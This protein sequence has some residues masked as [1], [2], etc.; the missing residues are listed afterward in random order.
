MADIAEQEPQQDR[1]SQDLARQIRDH[2]NITLSTSHVSGVNDSATARKNIVDTAEGRRA[3][4]SNYGNAPGGAV[5]LDVDMLTGMLGL[6]G[7]YRFRV[8][9][10]AGGSHSANSRHYAGVAFDVDQI[11]GRQVNSNNPDYQTFMQIGR[12]LGA[13]E[14]LGPGNVGHDTHV[15]LAWPRRDLSEKDDSKPTCEGGQPIT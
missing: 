4:R 12:T 13:T 7:T 1:T 9:E 2:A 14:V 10:I 15:H 5:D 3:Q 8:S 11:N 6:A